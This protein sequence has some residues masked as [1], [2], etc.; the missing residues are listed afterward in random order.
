MLY[1]W[2]LYRD[3]YGRTFQGRLYGLGMVALG[4]VCLGFFLVSL[5]RTYVLFYPSSSFAFYTKTKGSRIISR[6]AIVKFQNLNFKNFI[7]KTVFYLPHIGIRRWK[8]T[9]ST[10]YTEHSRL[11]FV[12]NYGIIWKQS[13]EL[14]FEKQFYKHFH[15]YYLSIKNM[16]KKSSY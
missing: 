7:R 3:N 2:P 12:T 6:Y 9:L 11:Y 10:K 4:N 13:F 5:L 8:V 16:K 15:S 1:L 14:H